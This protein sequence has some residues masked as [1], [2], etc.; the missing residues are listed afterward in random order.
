MIYT[1]V[2]MSNLLEIFLN[3]RENHSESVASPQCSFLSSFSSPFSVVEMKDA[4]LHN[5]VQSNQK[6]SSP[7]S[8][9]IPPSKKER[10][11]GF[12]GVFFQ[13]MGK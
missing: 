7:L 3:R 9:N 10:Y 5:V 13:Q 1:K 11:L 12:K 4:I 6:Q 2:Y 8:V